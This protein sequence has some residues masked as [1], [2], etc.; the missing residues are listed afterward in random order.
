M[1]DNMLKIFLL[2]TL[3]CITQLIHSEEN[4]TNELISQIFTME[5]E[6][7]TGGLGLKNRDLAN[8]IRSSMLQEFPIVSCNEPSVLSEKESRQILENEDYSKLNPE[9]IENKNI[10]LLV[11]ALDSSSQEVRDTAT[12]TL[13]L[14]GPSIIEIIPFIKAKRDDHSIKG[15]WYNH[16]LSEIDCY[17]SQGAHY[18]RVIPDNLFSI[19]NNKFEVHGNPAILL[20]DLF[21]NPN[22]EY[23]Q[24]LLSFFTFDSSKFKTSRIIIFNKLIEILINSNL[25]VNKRIDAAWALNGFPINLLNIQ[26]EKLV[27]LSTHSNKD[28]AK[29][30][31]Y[32][33]IK[34]RHPEGIKILKKELQEDLWGWGEDICQYGEEATELETD[35][36]NVIR[37][38]KD[39]NDYLDN[40]ESLGCIKSKK[41]IALLLEL[42]K[43]N[44]WE[45]AFRSIN[46]IGEIGENTKKIR[47]TLNDVIKTTW[48]K[49]VRQAAQEALKTLKT[50]KEIKKIIK[51][52]T[53]ISE[54]GEEMEILQPITIGWGPA[55][56]DHGMPWCNE[57]GKYSIDNKNWFNVDWNREGLPKAPAGFP[58]NLIPD[59]RTH[60]FYQVDDGWLFGSE[61]GHYD[62]TFIYWAPDKEAYY[63]ADEY[64]EIYSIFRYNNSILAIG[65]DI[66]DAGVLFKIINED[67]RW[68]AKRIMTLPSPPFGYAF[69]PN[70]ELFFSD[71][72]NDYAVIN[73][74]IVPLKCELKVEGSYFDN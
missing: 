11:E 33:L 38:N 55:A 27:D 7:Y 5:S 3:P 66:G 20:I 52:E 48:S 62:G 24:G 61:K 9:T 71:G 64:T 42:A 10:K 72:P 8:Q 58:N 73:N 47:K 23:P 40:I 59:Y 18:K 13:S 45:I 31:K 19:A 57:K 69:G 21:T 4:H 41:A 51:N 6:V 2:T 68:V 67:D 65:Y 14:F 28:L 34:T 53:Y 43:S 56:V 49:Q 36:I 60:T 63:I 26:N 25:S 12:Y 50:G 35:L 30:I 54:D 39:R 32:L 17:N 15:N 74:Q 16:A 46:S 70:N 29:A 44:D 1:D 37:R 22:I